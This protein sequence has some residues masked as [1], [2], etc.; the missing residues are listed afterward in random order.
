MLPRLGIGRY[1]RRYL[2]TKI[3][4]EKTQRKLAIK[5]GQAG[6]TPIAIHTKILPNFDQYIHVIP[7]TGLGSFDSNF[8]ECAKQHPYQQVGNVSSSHSIVIHTVQA[9]K[10]FYFQISTPA[11]AD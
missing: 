11:L 4:I 7:C 10:P 1:S 9:D 5:V 3:K 8:V 6:E 2:N